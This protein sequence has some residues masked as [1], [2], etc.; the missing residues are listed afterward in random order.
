MTAVVDAHGAAADEQV[1][2]LRVGWRRAVVD[3]LQRPA[4]EIGV[5]DIVLYGDNA[6]RV[7]AIT[8][9]GFASGWVRLDLAGPGSVE[10]RM[11]AR[12]DEP[13]WFARAASDRDARLLCRVYGDGRR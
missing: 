1:S 4:S 2:Y 6:M 9:T 11:T 10:A 5:G 3:L 13:V 7:R 8:T 12:S